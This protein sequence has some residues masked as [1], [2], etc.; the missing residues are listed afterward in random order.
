MSSEPPLNAILGFTELLKMELEGKTDAENLEHLQ[1]VYSAGQHLLTLVNELLDMGSIESG[2]VALSIE[3]VEVNSLISEAL[4]FVETSAFRKD[5]TF[6]YAREV[7]GV[8]IAEADPSRLKQIFINLLSNAVK[9]NKAKGKVGIDISVH[10][11]K[12]KFSVSDEGE[13]LTQ[14]QQMKAFNP[15]ERVGN[16]DEAIEGTGIGLTITRRLVELMGGEMGINSIPG[17]GAE[18]WFT[19][20]VFKETKHA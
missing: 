6:E 5:I 10:A 11:D 20:P 16:V 13:G 1:Y 15:F 12:Y 4:H 17:E 19:L 9:Y 3:A 14:D 2:K 18:F 7:H 8:V